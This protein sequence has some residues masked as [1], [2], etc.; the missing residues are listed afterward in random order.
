MLCYRMHCQWGRKP[1]KL[2]IPL[3]IVTSPE[4]ATAISNVHKKF[5]KDHAC[6]LEICSQADIQTNTYTDA[7]ITI[8]RPTLVGDIQMEFA[9]HQALSESQ[10]TVLLE[11]LTISTNVRCHRTY[12]MDD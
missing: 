9:L 5:G 1:P 10:W 4:R 2:P 8:L 6:V 7:L 12:I 11:Y 3:G